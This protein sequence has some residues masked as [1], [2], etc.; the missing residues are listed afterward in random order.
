M[1]TA[2][3]ICIILLKQER[4]REINVWKKVNY[5]ETMMNNLKIKF[6]SIL[7]MLALLAGSCS[8]ISTTEPEFFGVYVLDG[9][10]LTQLSSNTI[11]SDG[12]RVSSDARI[13][14]YLADA[15]MVTAQGEGPVLRVKGKLK[16]TVE[17]F[18][19]ASSVQLVRTHQPDP[20]AV[21]FDQKL[22][23]QLKPGTKEGSFEAVATGPLPAGW[24]VLDL[25]GEK[26][27]LHV[28]KKGQELPLYD[29][30][31]ETIPE[32]RAMDAITAASRRGM[33]DRKTIG[34]NFITK[35]YYKP[36]QPLD[37]LMKEQR[38]AALAAFERKEF[39]EAYE[40]AE[41]SLETFPEDEELKNLLEVAPLRAM[42]EREANKNWDRIEFWIQAWIEMTDQRPDVVTRGK[43]LRKTAALSEL[44]QLAEAGNIRNFER[45]L[46]K[47]NED[48]E[49]TKELAEKIDE[50]SVLALRESH[51]RD[52]RD[53]EEAED[54]SRALQFA[55]Q[56]QLAL[57]QP[58][59]KELIRRLLTT[60]HQKNPYAARFLKRAYA[61]NIKKTTSS[62]VS[63]TPDSSA[64]WI[65]R[66]HA[67]NEQL[68]K[69]STTGKVDKY[70]YADES[71]SRQLKNHAPTGIGHSV[72][73]EI[74]S[75][76][77]AMQVN[78]QPVGQKAVSYLILVNPGQSKPRRIEIDGS[79]NGQMGATGDWFFL[80]DESE[81]Q[82]GEQSF[83]ILDLSNN[84]VT[85]VSLPFRNPQ[86]VN[87]YSKD[88]IIRQVFQDR[89]G[90]Y[91]AVGNAHGV[92]MFQ[93]DGWK[94]LW[95][96]KI[97]DL[98]DPIGITHDGMRIHYERK[99]YGSGDWMV[100][101]RTTRKATRF[102]NTDGARKC[103]SD[104][105]LVGVV[106]S[107][108]KLTFIDLKDNSV[109]GEMPIQ[110]LRLNLENGDRLW[111]TDISP[112]GKYLSVVSQYGK[113]FL[114]RKSDL[115]F[116]KE[117]ANVEI[118]SMDKSVVYFLTGHGEKDIYNSENNSIA[119]SQV[120]ERLEAD[121]MDVRSLNLVEA[122]QVPDDANV[123]IIAGP[124]TL[125]SEPEL[126]MLR[127]FMNMRGRLAV[128]VDSGHDAGLITFLREFGVQLVPD[129]VVD[130]SRTLNGAD[131]H[132]M[133][134]SSHPI[135]D[136]M[137]NI[138][139]IFVRPR[140]VLPVVDPGGLIAADRLRFSPLAASTNQGWAEV[141]PDLAPVEY[142][143][144]RDQR[145]PIPIAAAVEWKV[146]D[147][148]DGPL[149]TRLVVVG[150]SLFAG[151]WLAH[152]GGMRLLQNSVSWL[153]EDNNRI[154]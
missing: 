25:Q 153:V 82:P 107:G 122:R 37:A 150:D 108:R 93:V 17:L 80:R 27:P 68:L 142:N 85:T 66:P 83:K 71:W 119:Y 136:S 44:R 89:A 126:E 23:L 147:S 4:Q 9:N 154:E 145:G 123:L 13:V 46:K 141:E 105:A 74:K 12:P 26:Y 94:L 1:A 134:Y 58:T 112:D 140:S 65:H 95:S 21:I 53:A 42:E 125:I 69:F 76:F 129:I 79:L 55:E 15:S 18:N 34:G 48:A 30:Y 62:T 41:A 152:D 54:W 36:A 91:L 20:K 96:G 5:K 81:P 7:L 110:A 92:A 109:M 60:L 28:A 22:N 64:F 33:M 8:Q 73:Q 67:Q 38:G 77:F 111:E 50:L 14:I 52:M 106:G 146:A 61:W 90:K 59:D 87:R 98:G 16:R 10:N 49:L 84:K 3:T 2:G 115:E 39:A 124:Q 29:Q 148:G 113:V 144:D 24:Y 117:S 88:H 51:L 103:I 86:N 11:Q 78:G 70:S 40:M 133:A 57:P 114:Y 72:N 135:T 149:W 99:S 131:V 102:E 121:Q 31:Y 128:L 100:Y 139:S 101:D 35:E 151:N 75:S 130:P 127:D 6:R 118:P 138:R 45:R 137:N 47:T 56:A 143:P 19:K 63:F 104:K 132:V 43:Q 116:S 120:R 32:S 97:K